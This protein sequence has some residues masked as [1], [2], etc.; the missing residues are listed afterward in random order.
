M[1]AKKTE[2]PKKP[3][4]GPMSKL[5]VLV[6]GQ[7]L[8]VDKADVQRLRSFIYQKVYDL[9]LAASVLAQANGRQLFE[10][11]DL[12]ITKGLQVLITEF[13]TMDV[14]I[15]LGP[16]LEKLSKLPPLDLGASAPTEALLPEVIG[17]LTLGLA[18]AFKII[19]PNMEKPSEADW[20][21]VE[22]IFDLL[23]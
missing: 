8:E 16:L 22:Q 5:E 14:Q 1:M 10:P 13:K 12:P 20:Q 3:H 11:Y 18:R 17:A 19:D 6:R 7:G 9:L 4:G 15:N 23:L 21:K 2:E